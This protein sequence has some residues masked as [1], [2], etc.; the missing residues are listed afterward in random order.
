WALLTAPEEFRNAE[1]AVQLAERA[2]RLS[3]ENEA[4]RALYRNTLGVAC[5]RAGRYRKAVEVL[6]VNLTAEQDSAL[7]FDLYFLAMSYHQL[8]DAVRARDYY[9]WAVRW[10][11]AQKNLSTR[12]AEELTMFKA[13]AEEVLG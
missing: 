4:E 3:P 1:K 13:E 12:H 5:Y 7:A 11:K 10:T 2:L 8:G 9:D 6:R